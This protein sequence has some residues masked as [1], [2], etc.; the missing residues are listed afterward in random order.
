MILQM[1]YKTKFWKIGPCNFKIS[2]CSFIQKSGS[3]QLSCCEI[4]AISIM[5]YTLATSVG[6]TWGL[7]I[8]WDLRKSAIARRQRSVMLAHRQLVSLGRRVLGI[9]VLFQDLHRATNYHGMHVIHLGNELYS[10]LLHSTQVNLIGTGL[11]W[12]VNRFVVQWTSGP[13]T[14]KIIWPKCYEKEMGSSGCTEKCHHQIYSFTYFLQQAAVSTQLID[15]F[16]SVVGDKNVSTAEI[17][18]EQHGRD[19]SY[20]P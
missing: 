14:A 5:L 15:A 2:R 3:S 20:H 19:E 16:S 6:G 7:L 1:K 18:R 10:H 8:G 17:I 4:Q 13:L 11:G 9:R 12:E